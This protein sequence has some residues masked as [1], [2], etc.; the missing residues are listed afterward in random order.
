MYKAY[1]GQIGRRKVVGPVERQARKAEFMRQC[2]RLGT[3]LLPVTRGVVERGQ[4]DV[5]HDVDKRHP[6]ASREHSP[7]ATAQRGGIIGGQALPVAAENADMSRQG[8]DQSAAQIGK[9][10]S[11]RG[12]GG[13]DERAFA[14]QQP[15]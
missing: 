11:L 2:Q 15:Q 3:Q 9:R 14:G 13:F 4:Q 1:A 12:L 7:D 5:G 6:R 8:R 10:G